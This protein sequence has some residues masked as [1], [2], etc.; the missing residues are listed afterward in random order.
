MSGRIVYSTDRP[1]EKPRRGGAPDTPA[2]P[3]KGVGADPADGVVRIRRETAGRGGKTVT[4]LT[5][6]PGGEPAARKLVLE[7]RRLCGAG[8]TARGGSVV[9]QGDH[10]DTI[11]KALTG[12]GLRVKRAGG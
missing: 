6:I 4:T 3:E 8:G 2:P 9:I 7:L 10:R 12:R 1:Q 11:E 5:G